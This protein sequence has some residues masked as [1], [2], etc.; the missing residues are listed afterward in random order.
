MG[1][2]DSGTLHHTCFVVHDVE[3]SAQALADALSIGPWNIWLLEPGEGTVR[4]RQVDFSFRV[5]IA[6]VGDSNFELLSP[7]SGDTLYVEHLEAHGEG[8]HHTC[9]A[10]PTAEAIEAAKTQFASQ[11]REQLQ[12]GSLGEFGEFCYFDVP[13]MGGV[14]ELLYLT[15]LPEPEKTIQ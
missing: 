3:K 9:I 2:G 15:G 13:E 4:G 5:A 7:V 11:G 12:S 10:Y 1:V 14:L 8:F 6:E